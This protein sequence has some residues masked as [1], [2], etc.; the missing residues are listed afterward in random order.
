MNRIAS[1]VKKY[2]IYINAICFQGIWFIAVL[3]QQ[4]A[5]NLLILLLVLHFIVSP[6]RLSD[7]STLFVITILGSCIDYFLSLSGVFIFSDSLFIPIW[8]VLLWSHFSLTLNHGLSWLIRTPLYIQVLFGAV[9]GSL[10]Y[11]AGAQWGAV[12]LRPEF[13]FGLLPLMVI[14]GVSLPVY[15]KITAHNRNYFDKK[16]EVN[17]Q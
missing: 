10:S 2:F 12:I 15:I 3:Y 6:T 5:I 9:F 13:L 4:D 17:K 8:L 14:W 16:S 11:Y 1:W 7:I